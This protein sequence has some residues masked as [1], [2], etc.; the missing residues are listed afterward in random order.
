MR[1]QEEEW[2]ALH[3]PIRDTVFHD[4]EESSYRARTAS[5]RARLCNNNCE[6]LQHEYKGMR[7]GYK[8]EVARVNEICRQKYE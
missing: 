4:H 2:S 1:K 5:A 6:K 3:I 7:G 8:K